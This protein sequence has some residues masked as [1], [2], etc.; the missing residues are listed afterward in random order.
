MRRFVW[1]WFVLSSLLVASL[2]AE[3]RPQYGGTLRVAMRAAPLSLD[4]ADKAQPDSFSRRGLAMLIFDTL[5]SNDGRAQASL[6]TSWQA[7][8][9]HQHWQLRLR[10]GVKFHD[11][12]LL[13]PEIAAASLRLADPSWN[14]SSDADSVTIDLDSP[15]PDLL[16]E[17]ALPRY[18][19]VKR[20]G[21]TLSGTGPFHIADWQPGKKLTL[22]A[23]ENCWRGRPFLDG[24]EIEMGRSYRDQ[25]MT[26]DMG[27]TDLVEIPAEQVHR[28]S[29]E[30]RTVM[31]SP[32]VE[33]LTLVFA[34]DPN[35]PDEKTLREALLLSV[36]R[37][38]MRSVLLQGEG[39]PSGGILPNWMSGY[40]F[41]FPVD[42]DL[43]KARHNRDQVR[44]LPT[45][46]LG[47]D[48][49]D[50]LARLLAERIALNGK[51]AGLSLQPTSSANADLRLA[52][53]PLE[54][55]APWVSLDQVARSAGLPEVKSKTNSIEELYAAEQ[56]VL[57]TQR[58]LPLF[59][60]PASY[61][62]ASAVKSWILQSNGSWSLADAWL[63]S[64]QP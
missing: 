36:E 16:A 13:T 28:A 42:A 53:I 62:A 54:S 34:R 46:T 5:V 63:G 12:T 41:V 45:W 11:G 39:Q 51:D 6:A 4:P 40:G 3:T 19:I 38:S 32:P 2:A 52:R 17:L 22:A 8:A 21:A 43:A 64:R 61:A 33:F 20:D 27:K 35:S 10:H 31:S 7:S 57:A 18:A 47:Y 25:M 49:T 29:L 56:S 37:T 30:G 15:D 9:N 59:H 14:I 44:S 23:E 1:Q 60:V 50:P 24:I 48:G 58:I 26:L 55:A